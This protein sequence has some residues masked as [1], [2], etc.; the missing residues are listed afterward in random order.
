ME[1]KMFKY[2]LSILSLVF[3]ISVHSSTFAAPKIDGTLMAKDESEKRI[4]KIKKDAE[5]ETQAE[6]GSNDW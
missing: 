3:L 5:R 6:G 2:A 4:E 1:I